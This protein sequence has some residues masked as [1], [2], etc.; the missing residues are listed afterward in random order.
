MRVFGAELAGNRRHR[1]LGG[2]S[3]AAPGQYNKKIIHI[4]ANPGEH[5]MKHHLYLSLFIAGAAMSIQS[6]AANSATTALPVV[7]PAATDA[8]LVASVDPRKTYSSYSGNRVW[9]VLGKDAA[10]TSIQR[11]IAEIPEPGYLDPKVSLFTIL[12]SNDPADAS[13]KALRHKVIKGMA[14]RQ[15]SGYESARAEIFSRWGY[16]G[17]TLTKGVPYWAAFAFYIDSDHPFDGSGDDLDILELGHPTSSANC[18]P[19]PAFYL[20]RNGR[21]DSMIWGNT[22]KDGGT[23]TRVGAKPFS[24]PI[25]KG[26]WHYVVVQFKLEWDVSKGPYFRVWRATGKGTPVQIASSSAANTWNEK[27]TYTPWKFGLYQWNINNWG[28]SP[29]RT[30][31]TK[32]VHIFKDQPGT[33]TLNVN[34]MLAFIRGI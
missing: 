22:V 26:V 19:S 5:E 1:Q 23:S 20:R 8:R 27:N 18:N 3:F 7:A 10:G 2:M 21:W 32:G 25:S 9:V 31:Y 29:S 30:V 12:R 28:S 17:T 4:D 33:P 14:Y 11:N 13:R 16:T 34:S 6:S 15:D 24:E